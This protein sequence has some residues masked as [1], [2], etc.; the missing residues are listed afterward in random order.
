MILPPRRTQG[1]WCRWCN[2]SQP[3]TLFANSGEALLHWNC[4]S[5]CAINIF[6]T[7]KLVKTALWLPSFRIDLVD[8]E[9]DGG[10]AIDKPCDRD[11][12]TVRT[13]SFA[14]CSQICSWGDGHWWTQPWNWGSMWGKLRA[15][16]VL[17]CAGSQVIFSIL[18][19]ANKI[20]RG[21]PK[22]LQIH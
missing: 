16:S 10:S 15:A 5:I 2:L 9:L 4:H 21:G 17:A 12:V 22:S 6:Q 1:L 18:I 19:T 11:S 20:P 13:P 7:M 8:F 3:R 14:P